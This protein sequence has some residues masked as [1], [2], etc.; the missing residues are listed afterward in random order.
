MTKELLQLFR[1]NVGFSGILDFICL[2]YKANIYR[3][4]NKDF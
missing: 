1:D 3:Q 4:T 2:P